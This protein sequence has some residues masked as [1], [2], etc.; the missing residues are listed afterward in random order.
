MNVDMNAENSSSQCDEVLRLLKD[1][2]SITSREM[3]DDYG[4]TR[5]AA[6]VHELRQKGWLIDSLPVAVMNRYG[7]RVRVSQYWLADNEPCQLELI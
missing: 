5:L 4:I 2:R 1:G 6:R 3:I 7:R